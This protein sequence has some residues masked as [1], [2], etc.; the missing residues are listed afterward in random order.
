MKTDED[1][2]FERIKRESAMYEIQRLGQKMQPEKDESGQPYHWD[3][4]VSPSQRNQVLEEVA[5]KLAVLPYGMTSAIFADF[6]RNMK[7]D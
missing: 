2:E 6:V 3:V 7:N 1:Y 5:N 4:Y